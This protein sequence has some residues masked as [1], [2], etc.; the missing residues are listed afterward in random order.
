AEQ[1]QKRLD[2]QAKEPKP[3]QDQDEIQ[4]ARARRD[5]IEANLAKLRDPQLG[6]LPDQFICQPLPRARLIRNPD[7]PVPYHKRLALVVGA[8]VYPVEPQWTG[9]ELRAIE[10]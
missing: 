9:H 10:T 4:L 6:V 5:E 3:K 1:Q 2:Q 7:W 8:S